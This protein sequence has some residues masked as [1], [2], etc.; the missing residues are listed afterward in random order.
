MKNEYKPALGFLL[1][2]TVALFACTPAKADVI[3]DIGPKRLAAFTVANG[4]DKYTTHRCVNIRKTCEESGIGLSALFGKR[5]SGGELAGA[6]V[7]DEIL[8]VGG[9]IAL[10]EA[11]GYDGDGMKYFQI[12]MIGSRG[13]IGTLNLRF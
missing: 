4:F 13:V 2:S 12:G 7:L 5:P 6:F 8:Y 3:Q 10:G 11:F 1:A 9:S